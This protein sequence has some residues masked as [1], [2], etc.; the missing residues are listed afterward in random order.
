MLE[1]R[2]LQHIYHRSADLRESHPHVLI[3][4]GDD[5][6]VLLTPPASL[7]KV[8]QLIEGV[9]FSC[10]TPIDLIARK[11]IARTLSDIAAMAGTP[12][13]ALAACVLPKGYPSHTAHALF[14]AVA[15]W[16]KH[17]NAPVIGGDIA[18]HTDDHAPLTL[19]INIIGEPHAKRGP[20]LRS[21]TQEGD[22]VYVTGAL[23]GSLGE[24]FQGRHLTFSPRL[25]EAAFL[26]DTLGE[27]LHAMMDISDGLGID[28]ARMATASSITIRIEGEQ[29]PIH[30]DARAAPDSLLSA[31]QDGEDYELLFAVA[32]SAIVPARCPHTQTVFTRIGTAQ[33]QGPMAAVLT[34][35]GILVDAGLLG[36][37][38][39]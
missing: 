34:R 3:G 23:G 35:R 28:A 26:A 33:S 1:S 30:P 15:K 38:H 22:H 8:D 17:W 39:H 5:C 18:S 14:D 9:H 27:S 37:D 31:I 16:G 11:A 32:P 10:D 2:L 13:A 36:W 29:I 19:C 21:T 12:I 25:T 6:A 20:V 7:L 24:G 4:P